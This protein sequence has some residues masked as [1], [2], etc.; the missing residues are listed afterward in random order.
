MKST[1]KK[2]IK[3]K[4]S[5]AGRQ[6]RGTLGQG[7]SELQRK[8][9]RRTVSRVRRRTGRIIKPAQPL[10]SP[11]PDTMRVKNALDRFSKVQAELTATGV[12]LLN[13]ARSIAREAVDQFKEKLVQ[14]LVQENLLQDLDT[15]RT[16]SES[17][18]LPPDLRLL[19]EAMLNWVC[20]HLEI[21][22]H[23]QV[24]KRF[25]IPLEN[26]PAYDLHGPPPETPN[27][28]VNIEVLAPGWKYRGRDLIRPRVTLFSPLP[29]EAYPRGSL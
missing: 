17:G 29:S 24:G 10:D 23:L 7:R 27:A 18:V 2:T 5:S 6:S 16:V 19:A 8:L 21:I 28:L 22:Q 3:P 1:P 9:P 12:D 11:R 25:E 26:V 4:L 14:D 15:L 13:V 20:Q